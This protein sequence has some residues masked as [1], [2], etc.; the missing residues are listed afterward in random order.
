VRTL[1]IIK[2][3]AVE[4]NAIGFCLQMAETHGLKIRNI[5][6]TW[7]TREL[8]RAFYLEHADKPFYEKLVTFM[9]SGPCVA[10]ELEGEDA[11]K[12]WR[13]VMT[14]IRSVEADKEL[15]ERNAVHGSD[16]PEAAERE[17]AFFFGEA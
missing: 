6:K 5:Q 8:A 13:T 9:A 17:V 2:P 7:L 11:V 3:D 16:S 12:T 15:S 4:K 1:A 10:V 14:R